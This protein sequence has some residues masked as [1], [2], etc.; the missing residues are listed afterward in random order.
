MRC[1]YVVVVCLTFGGREPFDL[2]AG[3]GLC[4]DVE[5]VFGWCFIMID[6]INRG[7]CVRQNYVAH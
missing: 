4:V 6:V 7:V 2:A 3:Y 5:L 1:G